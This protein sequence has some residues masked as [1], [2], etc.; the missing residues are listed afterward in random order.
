MFKSWAADSCSGFF[1]SCIYAYAFLFLLY[2]TSY[3]FKF[4]MWFKKGLKAQ[5]LQKQHTLSFRACGAY[6][7]NLNK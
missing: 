3:R 5:K 7:R 2:F 4:S 1:V 6:M